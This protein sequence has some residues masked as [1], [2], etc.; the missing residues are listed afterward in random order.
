[1]RLPRQP[2][3]SQIA[4]LIRAEI[5]A[6]AYEPSPD[7]PGRDLLPGA[8]E[9]GARFGVSNKTAARAIQ[10]LVAE[11]LVRARP[12]MRPLVIPR[13]ERPDRWPM[14]GRYARAR[15][16]M[17]VVFGGDMHGRE[18]TKQDTGQGGPILAPDQVA[19]LLQLANDRRVIWRSRHK[20]I[21]G[22]VAETSTSYFPLELAAGTPLARSEP[23]GPGGMV[24]A[25]ESFGRRIARTINEV[26]ARPATTD[27]LDLFAID[28][29]TAP[30]A[31][32][33]MLEVTHATYGDAGEPLEAVIS[34]RPASNAVIVFE[35]DER[36]D[37]TTGQ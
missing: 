11:G 7:Q 28:P 35:T 37:P 1:M 22:R 12:G 14:Q 33:I 30:P 18:V 25:L 27:E 32:R 4:D 31:D 20:L 3:Y 2:A 24:A 21:D 26:R 19:A 10:Q 6:G 17:G 34:V 5:L 23:L 29:A 9:L 15:D 36:P 13:A 8:A 16:R